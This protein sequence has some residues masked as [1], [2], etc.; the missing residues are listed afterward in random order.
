MTSLHGF[1]CHHVVYTG[2]SP[3]VFIQFQKNMQNKQIYGMIESKK[4]KVQEG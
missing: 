1:P 4:Q 3:A 2:F